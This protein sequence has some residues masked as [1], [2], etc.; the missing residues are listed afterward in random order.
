MNRKIE[1]LGEKKRKEEKKINQQ[2]LRVGFV[3]VAAVPSATRRMGAS[4]EEQSRR[5]KKN[6]PKSAT[7]RPTLADVRTLTKLSS[8]SDD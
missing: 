4:A 3:F 7:C 8:Q 5:R 6:H 2:K 1:A